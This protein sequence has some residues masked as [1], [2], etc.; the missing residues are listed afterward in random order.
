MVKVW[1]MKECESISHKW[2]IS[3]TSFTSFPLWLWDHVYGGGATERL[4]EPEVAYNA[5]KIMFSRHDKSPECTNPQQGGAC[6][7]P[8]QRPR[9]PKLQSNERWGHDVPPKVDELLATDDI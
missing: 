6:R 5:W 7:W 8:A 1:R 4:Q 3:V 2:G 9:Q